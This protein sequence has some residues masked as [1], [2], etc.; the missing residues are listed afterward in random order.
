M[1]I[2]SLSLFF[3]AVALTACSAVPGS[4]GGDTSGALDSYFAT[5]T[6]KAAGHAQAMAEVCP[7][8][9][10]NQAELDLHRIAI[11]RGGRLADDCAVPRLAAATQQAFEN[12]MARLAGLTPA[13][14]CSQ[15]N[16]EMAA[17]PVFR[18]YIK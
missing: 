2:K 10:F 11:C 12:T 7:S 6:G 4:F 13:E 17:N 3:C 9:S 8:M 5:S 15:A 1:K 14:V 18:K 16:A